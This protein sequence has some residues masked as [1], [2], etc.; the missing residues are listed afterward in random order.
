MYGLHSNPLTNRNELRTVGIL[1][2]YEYD[3]K[4]NKEFNYAVRI[5]PVNYFYICSWT[6][7]NEWCFQQLGTQGEREIRE[8]GQGWVLDKLKETVPPYCSS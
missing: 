5:N 2:G 4:R 1:S 7:R 6:C 8:K 3:S